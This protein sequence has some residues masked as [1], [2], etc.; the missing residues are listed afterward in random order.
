MLAQ[1]RARGVVRIQVSDPAEDDV[2]LLAR[3]VADALG[4]ARAWVTPSVLGARA[5]AVLAPA[6]A[7]VLAEAQLGPGDALLV[8]SGRTM[9]DVA[10]HAL[11]PLPGVLVAPNVGGVDEADEANH[12][13]DVARRIAVGSGATPV[14]FHAPLSPGADLHRLLAEQPW[15][16]RVTRLWASARCALVGIGTPPRHRA[17][18]PAVMQ[19]ERAALAAA[20]GDICNRVYDAAGDEISYPGSDHLFAIELAQ[21]AA[22]PHAVGVAVGENKAEAIAVAARAGFVNR[23]VTDAQ[24]ARAILALS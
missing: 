11:G 4:L 5:G 19:L 8:S 14:M 23:L 18:L 7:S 2:E 15:I 1:A 9:F 22:V 6:V 21:L 10:R 12:T 13:N 16:V 17:A 3:K 20:V 24:T